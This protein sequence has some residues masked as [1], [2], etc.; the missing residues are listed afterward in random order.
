VLVDHAAVEAAIADA[1]AL[2]AAGGDATAAA[3]EGERLVAPGTKL[4]S[5]HT[6]FS[7]TTEGGAAA[8]RFYNSTTQCPPW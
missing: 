6:S 2:I 8:E 4:S 3:A 7:G 5:M 1:Q